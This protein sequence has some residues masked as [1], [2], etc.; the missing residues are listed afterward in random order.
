MPRPIQ[1]LIVIPWVLLA[2]LCPSGM[3]LWIQ[4]YFSETVG[5]VGAQVNSDPVTQDEQPTGLTGEH[6][7]TEERR[8]IF[9]IKELRK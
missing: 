1:F 4:I 5:E 8:Q 2:L 7:A 3:L 6:K 9:L